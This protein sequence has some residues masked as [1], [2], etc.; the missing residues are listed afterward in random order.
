MREIIKEKTKKIFP[1]MIFFMLV[2]GSSMSVNAASVSALSIIPGYTY[3]CSSL[4][5]LDGDYA[6]NIDMYLSES[7]DDVYALFLKND[8]HSYCSIL[9]SKGNFKYSSYFEYG[10][11]ENGII[12][13]PRVNGS[14]DTIRNSESISY[15]GKTYYY[16]SDGVDAVF[17]N[18]FVS[19]T[20]PLVDLDSYSDGSWFNSSTKGELFE[21]MY[22]ADFT[23][24]DGHG[25]GG[26]S[27]AEYEDTPTGS[28][29]P[30]KNLSIYRG[31]STSDRQYK[32]QLQWEKPEDL[33]L[34]TEITAQI[35][36]KNG[37][38]HVYSNYVVEGR[39]GWSAQDNKYTYYEN[40]LINDF[41]EYKEIDK[42]SVYNIEK[43]YVRFCKLV[44][45]KF[46]YSL[47]R[48]VDYINLDSGNGYDAGEDDYIADS[49][50]G[51]FDE[52][53][54]WKDQSVNNGEIVDGAEKE[55]AKS[56]GLD[57]DGNNVA[58]P[59]KDILNPDTWGIDFASVFQK[60]LEAMKE[61]ISFIGEFPKAISEFFGFLPPYVIG[62]VIIGILAAIL[63]RI[64][65]R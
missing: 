41:F 60:F 16:A 8:T 51:S 62:C 1:I 26:G 30:P 34:Y 54:N 35:H 3:S 37:S 2:F 61:A 45:G 52:N 18:N 14:L 50:T 21:K 49:I 56:P 63:L 6:L 22:S 9:V 32:F 7:T 12:A 17:F 29:E 39:D 42:P 36:Y 44:D 13:N 47:W 58:P 57:V 31:Y 15:N 46:Q 20:S 55:N 64:L 23:W 19:S 27:F 25:G 11:L 24:D 4:F 33:E 53:G 28:I 65:G 59:N 10:P 40:D 5:D 48:M 38:E 43:L